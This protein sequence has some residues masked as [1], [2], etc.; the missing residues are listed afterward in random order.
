[1]A[2]LDEIDVNQSPLLVGQKIGDLNFK[3]HRL[4]CI[5]LEHAGEEGEFVFNPSA[6]IVLEA[7]DVLLVMGRKVSIEHFRDIY[8]KGNTNA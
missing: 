2:L 4:I 6:E 3:Q 8:R 1:M 7:G 5:G